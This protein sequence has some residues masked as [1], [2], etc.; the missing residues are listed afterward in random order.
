MTQLLKTKIKIRPNSKAHFAINI[1]LCWLAKNTLFCSTSNSFWNINW[2]SAVRNLNTFAYARISN[3]LGHSF[4]RKVGQSDMCKHRQKL[5]RRISALIEG[6]CWIWIS[7][8]DWPDS[9][10]FGTLQSGKTKYDNNS[11]LVSETLK[12]IFDGP[13]RLISG[14]STG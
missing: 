2:L 6:K 7:L 9:R 13:Q 10:I 14:T 8:S 4:Q 12:C 3:S 5:F 11:P 1:L